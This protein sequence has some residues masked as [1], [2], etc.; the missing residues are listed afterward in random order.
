MN[1]WQ[2]EI[3]DKY[4]PPNQ[5]FL[6]VSDGHKIIARV[7][8]EKAR[9]GTTKEEAKEYAA[10]IAAAPDLLKALQAMDDLDKLPHLSNKWWKQAEKADKLRNTAIKKAT[11]KHQHNSVN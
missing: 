2:V 8:N 3:P 11:S 7:L 10:L 1:Y 4:T 5:A 9:V 6:E